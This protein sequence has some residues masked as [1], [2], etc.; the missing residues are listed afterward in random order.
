[1]QQGEK[2]FY[3]RFGADLVLEKPR[4]VAGRFRGYVAVNVLGHVDAR[5]GA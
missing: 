4:E 2:Y 1:M 3:H 5:Q